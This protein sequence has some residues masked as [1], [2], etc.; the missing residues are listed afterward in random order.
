MTVKEKHGNSFL[1]QGG[2]LAAAGVICRLIGILRRIPLANIIGDS[3]NAFFSAANEIYIIVLML[4][5]YSLP[6]AVSK[7]V[8]DRLGR[9]EYKNAFRVFI[10]A[11]AFATVF[12][13]G[14]ALLVF[15]FADTLA[16]RFMLEPLAVLPLKI[17]SP[18]IF[19][20]A[21]VGVFRGYFQGRSNMVPT[22][23]S[24]I[25][26]QIFL[27]VSCLLGAKLMYGY[28]QKA[29]AL[30]HNE[31]LAPAYGAA[32]ATIGT[33]VGALAALLFLILVYSLNYGQIRLQTVRDKRPYPEKYTRIARLIFITLLPMILNQVIYNISNVLDQSIFNHIMATKGVEDL[34]RVAWGVY[35]GKYRVLQTVPVAFASAL[36]A[37]SLPV[38]SK[39]NGSGLRKNL[40]QKAKLAVRAAMLVVIP[41]T[42]G[43]IVL[44]K[45]VMALL[46]TTEV[47]LAANLLRIGGV[48]MIFLAMS[49]LTSS[50]LQGIDRLADPVRNAFGGLIVHLALIWLLVSVFNMGIYGVLISNI[51]LSLVISV[52]NDLSLK[53]HLSFNIDLIKT[54]LLPGIASAIMGGVVALLYSLVSRLTGTMVSLLISIVAGVAVYVVCILLLGCAKREELMQMPG[55]K[56]LVKCFERFGIFK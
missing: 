46:F 16:G 5:S 8:S 3:G 42:A 14:A 24:Q 50:L 56:P 47:D 38:I 33:G 54:F 44:A 23:L 45:P 43:L 20:V 6:A 55:T 26:E 2:I 28:G 1:I 31:S 34:N 48:C 30:L 12:G 13:A 10:G 40:R 7:L 18:T 21:I 49:S 35:S 37:A 11:L 52:L 53:K 39:L 19:I 9:K 29:G 15:V 41:S 17:L 27:V 32:G 4:S 51:A 22:A 25:I 36:G